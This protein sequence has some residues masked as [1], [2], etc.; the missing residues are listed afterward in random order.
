V[1]AP[2]RGGG[3]AGT[4]GRSSTAPPG[5][6]RRAPKLCALG[7]AAQKRGV[8]V[9]VGGWVRRRFLGG[10]YA[11]PGTGQRGARAHPHRRQPRPG[12]RWTSGRLAA[13]RPAGPAAGRRSPRHHLPASDAATRA[14][15][16]LTCRRRR[17]PVHPVRQGA[18]HTQSVFLGFRQAASARRYARTARE[19]HTGRRPWGSTRAGGPRDTAR[20][21]EDAAGGKAVRRNR[22]DTAQPRGDETGLAETRGG[23]RRRSRC[24]VRRPRVSTG[25]R[26]TCHRGRASDAGADAAGHHRTSADIHGTGSQPVACHSTRGGAAGKRHPVPGTGGSALI[27]VRAWPAHRWGG[28]R[29]A[30]SLGDRQARVPLVTIHVAG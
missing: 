7:G 10:R 26:A 25:V 30:R 16:V 2:W 18:R 23:V 28:L 9:V 8:R 14:R 19:H 6:R 27:C 13:P 29:V 12:R 3:P 15:R 5:R 4:G 1:T 21:W 20:V 24:Q 22:Y 11:P 17:I